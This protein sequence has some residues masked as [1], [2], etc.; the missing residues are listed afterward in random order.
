MLMNIRGFL[1]WAS[2]SLL[3]HVVFVGG[4]LG[5]VGSLTGLYLN[6]VEGSLTVAWGLWVVFVSFLGG[7]AVA[8]FLWY[9]ASLPLIKRRNGKR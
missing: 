3:G 2:H 8:I 5:V 4:L 1:K 9:T 7:V 6:Y